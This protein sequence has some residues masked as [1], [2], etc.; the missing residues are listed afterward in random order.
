M[1]K[2]F[3]I[4]LLLVIGLVA[5]WMIWRLGREGDDLTSMAAPDVPQLRPREHLK[6][7]Q[8]AK[9]RELAAKVAAAAQPGE[10]DPKIN[11]SVGR[12]IAMLGDPSP[13]MRERANAL[14]K[15]MPLP[16][17][18]VVEAQ[19]LAM[20]DALDVEARARMDASI[21]M[22]HA[23]AIVERRERKRVEWWINQELSAYLEHGHT[24]PKWD[25]AA[26]NFLAHMGNYLEL[27]KGPEVK[28]WSNELA[29]AG[30]DDPLVIYF[31]AR[32]FQMNPEN[33]DREGLKR[34][35][36]AEEELL[37]SD[38]PA[39]IEAQ[40]LGRCAAMAEQTS[41]DLPWPGNG[42][43]AYRDAAVA[44]LLHAPEAKDIP[45]EVVFQIGDSLLSSV[46]EDWGL[47]Q[48]NEI[49][50]A[51]EKL[52]PGSYQAK[53]LRAMGHRIL[54]TVI[55]KWEDERHPNTSKQRETDLANAE[56][57]LVEAWKQCSDDP[58]IALEMMTVKIEQGEQA[59][60][61]KWFH[62]AME[63]Y[64]DFY[65]ACRR[66]S[67]AMEPE[68]RM[69]FCRELALQENYRGNLPFLLIRWHEW[70]AENSSEKEVYWIQP[71]VW[72]DV[73]LSLAR[74]LEIWPDNWLA[75]N[76]YAKCCVKCG[77]W[78]EAQKQ[79]AIIG[80]KPATSVFGSMTSYNYYRRKT[81]RHLTG[82]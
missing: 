17:A 26:L 51:M 33:D 24:S 46:R 65:E 4:G 7:E 41:L 40:T 12:A 23:L 58:A 54:A 74:Q 47:R 15:N 73:K 34:L 8:L 66:R 57:C 42:A 44:K 80:E 22:F 52:A 76:A 31:Q 75:R 56:K 30:C 21:S 62:K 10:N 35:A 82:G 53:V 50:N 14:L 18:P 55:P 27:D 63:L 38:Y 36:D 11:E 19:Y 45:P 48:V 70:M 43:H 49:C 16:D 6:G 13:R 78:A 81:Q 3:R 77:Q 25:Q 71:G 72:E 68:E 28:Q 67:A 79:F 9:A 60:S 1:G 32:L 29:S 37:A 39:A 59:E 5:A 64:P 69:K 20:K 61:E 2:P